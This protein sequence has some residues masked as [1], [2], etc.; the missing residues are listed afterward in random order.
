MSMVNSQDTPALRISYSLLRV[1]YKFFDI[2]QKTRYY[3]TDHPL[4]YVEIHLISAIHRNE[5]VHVT[6]LAEI[7]G[8]TK[9]A[10]SQ[11]LMKLETKG[12]VLKERDPLNQSRFLLKLTPKGET[13]HRHHIEFH[14]KF[15]ELVCQ[16]LKGQTD[17]NVQFLE[18]FIEAFDQKLDCWAE[19]V[20]P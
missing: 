8:V 14:N 3:G 5:G 16:I 19:I 6:G 7:L 2:D 18:D 12:Y 10:V 17:G 9:G 13:A 11:V 20:D 1:I 15:D 4:S